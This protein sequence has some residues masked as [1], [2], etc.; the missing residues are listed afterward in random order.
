MFYL[1]RPVSAAPVPAVLAEAGRGGGDVAYVAVAH[2]FLAQW[3][4]SCPA[5]TVG[6][7]TVAGRPFSVLRTEPAGC[8]APVFIPGK[9]GT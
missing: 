8:R 9:E 7:G 4:L 2:R 6:A 5:T 1:D 3:P